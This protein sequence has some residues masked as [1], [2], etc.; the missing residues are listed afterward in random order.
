MSNHRNQQANGN[1]G[2]TVG[3]PPS[4]GKT[5]DVRVWRVKKIPSKRAGAKRN[6]ATYRVRWVVAGRT[7]SAN[8][9]TTALAESERAALMSAARRG[10]A[11]DVE[12]GQPSIRRATAGPA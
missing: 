12:T 5:F 11:F 2:S 1:D 7:F 8:F 10:E 6:A 9:A 4:Q 3:E